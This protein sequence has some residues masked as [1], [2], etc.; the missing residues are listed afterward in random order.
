MTKTEK[1]VAYFMTKLTLNQ[2][3]HCEEQRGKE[4]GCDEATA[5]YV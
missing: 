3:C 1:N 5:S 2:K 4:R